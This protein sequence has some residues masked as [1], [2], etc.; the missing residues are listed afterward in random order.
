MIL[1]VIL[2]VFALFCLWGLI[3]LCKKDADGALPFLLYFCLISFFVFGFTI[4]GLTN[5]NS[6]LTSFRLEYKKVE[7]L[8]QTYDKEKDEKGDIL[9]DIKKHVD[10]IN[11]RITQE[12]KGLNRVFVKEMYVK[13]IAETEPIKFD[14]NKL[15]KEDKHE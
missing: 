2:I 6:E 15:I 12:Q 9:F 11:R 1:L 5:N 8:I 3:K 10:N 13:E 4:N 7:Y 14:F